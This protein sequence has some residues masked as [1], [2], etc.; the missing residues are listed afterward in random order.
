LQDR[1]GIT[2]E[3]GIIDE[4]GYFCFE[5]RVKEMIKSSGFSVFPEDVES[6][7]SDHPATYHSAVIGV[8]VKGKGEQVKAF[9]VVNPAH[10][11]KVT[12]KDLIKWSNDKM[13]AYKYPREIEF[14]ERLPVTSSGKVLRRIL[15]EE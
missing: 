10:K 6:L 14:L 4:Q 12:E 8:P 5:G 9:I 1:R 11:N 15:N 3:I 2:G 7:F 13:A